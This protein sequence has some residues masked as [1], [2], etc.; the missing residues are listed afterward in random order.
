[1]KTILSHAQ[2]ILYTLLDLIPSP[3]QIISFQAIFALFFEPTDG[4]M[5]PEH[6]VIKSPAAL[7]RFVTFLKEVRKLRHHAI[8]GIPKN[9]KLEDGRKIRTIGEKGQPVKLSGFKDTVSA[10]WFYL[11]QNGKLEKRFVI[12]TR[13]LKGNTIT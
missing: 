6:S 5:L 2:I 13:K 12:S 8:V 4:R 1:M 10:S 3:H 11:E 9:R 7:S